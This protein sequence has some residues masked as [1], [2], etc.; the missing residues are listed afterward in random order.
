VCFPE[1]ERIEV[2]ESAGEAS[3]EVGFHPGS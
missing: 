2:L 3:G 1:L